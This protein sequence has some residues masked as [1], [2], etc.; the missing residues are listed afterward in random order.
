MR[1]QLVPTLP[2]LPRSWPFL[3]G[4]LAGSTRMWGHASVTSGESING[5][6]V[7]LC[8]QRDAGTEPGWKCA[9]ST[10]LPSAC[11]I[12]NPLPPP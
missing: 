9:Y 7:S 12:Q 3:T 1:S 5:S 8:G 2:T 4:P 10:I 6:K 11:L